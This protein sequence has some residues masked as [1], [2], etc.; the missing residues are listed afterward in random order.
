MN[1]QP[2]INKDISSYLYAGDITIIEIKKKYNIS[3]FT[4]M[5]FINKFHFV[6]NTLMPVPE[7]FLY[8]IRI[9]EAEQCRKNNFTKQEI[10]TQLF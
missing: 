6:K 9:G 10:S 8:K 7:N 1:R 2:E 3:H 5:N 4:I